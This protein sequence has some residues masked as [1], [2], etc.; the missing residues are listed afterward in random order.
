MRK[1]TAAVPRAARAVGLATA[2]ALALP[3]L[4]VAT[5]ANA[6]EDATVTGST[7]S[8]G[9]PANW[10]RELPDAQV[11]EASAADGDV[12]VVVDP[13]AISQPYEGIGMS[14]DETSVSNLWALTPAEREKAIRMLADPETG[15]GMDLFRIVIGTADAVNHMPFTSLGDLPDGVEED[16]DFKHFSIQRDYDNHVIETAKMIKEINPDVRFY[17]SAWSAP[18]WMKTNNQFQGEVALKE[19][20]KDEHYQVGV[21]REDRVD[22]LANYYVKFIQAYAAEGIDIEAL[23]VLNEPGMDVQYPAMDIPVPLQQKVILAMRDAFDAAGFEGTEVWAH[24]F[25]YWDW[26]H[27]SDS[28]TKNYYR[29]LADSADGSVKGDDVKDALSAIAFHP[30]WGD[31]SV[32]AETN[33]E[34]GL[35]SHVTETQASGIGT[36]FDSV[37]NGASSYTLW[38][39]A[40]DQNGGRLYWTDSREPIDDWE[41]VGDKTS[42][43]DRLIK[44]NTESKSATYGRDLAGIGQMAR[45]VSFG[46]HLV[47]SSSAQDGIS[48]VVYVSDAGDFTAVLRNSNSSETK[49]S[50]IVAGQSVTQALPANSTSTLQWSQEL[51]S[52]PNEPPVLSPLDDMTVDQNSTTSFQLDATD[53]DGD[54]L[55]YY[56]LDL[57]D[58]VSVNASTGEVTVAPTTH[59]TFTPTF[60]VTDG[61]TRAQQSMTLTV[62]PQPVPVGERIE[63]ENFVSQTGWDEGADGP[64]EQNANASGGANIGWTAAGQTLTYLI[65]VPSDGTYKIEAALANGRGSTV[66]EG[67]TFHDE[68]GA[69]LAS[70]DSEATDGWASFDSSYATGEL[71]AGVQEITVKINDWGFNIDYF[72]LTGPG[73]STDPAEPTEEPTEPADPSDSAEPTEPG[74]TSGPTGSAEPAEDLPNTGANTAPVV[75]A[76]ILLLAGG[77]TLVVRRRKA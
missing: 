62:N 23:T 8:G 59:G 77:I 40:T 56:G 73:D 70:M 31:A 42:W 71:R 66:A 19:G 54:T 33:A 24:D 37:R 45:N 28:T 39:Q 12:S 25:N 51:P 58:G 20:S 10:W 38:V 4:A 46:D 49:V 55:T 53:P 6:D 76:A 72:V 68:D 75:L 64:I 14:L 9:D 44:V 52:G 16:P 2:C 21:L 35:N 5:A 15:A 30:Y 36:I 13:A 74:D 50:L 11:E 27:P 29:I 63:A 26:K 17:G 48:N 60:V 57:P 69:L 18:G 3:T 34:T 22:D 43:P 47:Q 7:S 61:R 67:L 65:D 32:M 1:A 41:A